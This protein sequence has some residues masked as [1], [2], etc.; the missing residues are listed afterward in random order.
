[1]GVEYRL[2]PTM[3]SRRAQ[4]LRFITAYIEAN[5]ISPS[6]DEIKE[7]LDV[8]KSRARELVA[9]LAAEG[10]II[11]VRGE[12]RSITL[13]S[14]RDA[15]IRELRAA[16]YI[17]DEDIGR[18]TPPRHQSATADAARARLPPRHPERGGRERGRAC[19]NR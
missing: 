19:G 9:A 3:A 17:V 10:R 5:A 16:G 14:I 7:A 6:Y 18:V 4:A 1:M 2:S 13:P 8:G 12:P 11:R 15:A